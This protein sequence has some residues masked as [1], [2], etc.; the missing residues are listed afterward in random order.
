MGGDPGAP[1]GPLIVSPVDHFLSKLATQEGESPWIQREFSRLT[2]PVIG[3]AASEDIYYRTLERIRGQKP[4]T[5]LKLGYIA[6]FFMGEYD[7]SSMPLEEEDW[8]EIRGTVEDASEAMNID[9]LT[10]LMND[11][12]SKGLL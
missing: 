4:T 3:K 1:K 8:R 5:L 12:L 6:A 11:L 9:T 7:E 10:G 2:A